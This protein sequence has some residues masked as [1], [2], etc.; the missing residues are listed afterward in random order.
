MGIGLRVLASTRLS[1][2]GGQD[3]DVKA[4]ESDLGD[5]TN[6]TD[7]PLD[8]NPSSSRTDEEGFEADDDR[9]IDNSELSPTPP[10][11]SVP[12]KQH[13]SRFQEAQL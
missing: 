1:G 2:G 5:L 9:V 12:K 4:M 10:M 13:A 3:G 11:D 7:Q 8:E 6:Q